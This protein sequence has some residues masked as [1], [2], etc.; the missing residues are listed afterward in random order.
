MNKVHLFS[1]VILLIFT[2]HA[3]SA[4]VTYAVESGSRAVFGTTLDRQSSIDFV[5]M[6]DNGQAE[7]HQSNSLTISTLAI[8]IPPALWLFG[9]GLLGLIGI[10]RRKRAV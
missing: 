5:S 3:Q 2:T 4:L 6:R 8:P 9:S 1:A 10:A 7:Q